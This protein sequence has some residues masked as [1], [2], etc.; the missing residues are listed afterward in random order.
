MQKFLSRL[1]K[2]LM[3]SWSWV[4]LIV[5]T[6]LIKWASWYP[7][8]VENQY[9]YGVYPL[10]TRVQRFLFG[11]I[12]FSIGDLFY[13]FLVLVVIFRT[14]RFF[15]FLFQKKITR[16]FFVGAMQQTIFFFLFVYVFFNLLWGLNYN[17]KGISPQL[18]IEVRKYSLSDIDSL[19]SVLQLRV[20]EYADSASE[21]QRDSFAKKRDLFRES[22]HAYEVISKK[23]PFLAYRPVSVKPSLFSYLGNYLGFQGYYNP[24][25]G[26][27]QVNTTVPRFLEPFI[28]TH[29]IAHQLG[30]GK[31][32]E[33]NFVAFL[34][35]KNHPSPV[36]KYSMYFD[37]YN[38]AINELHK[39][40]STKARSYLRQLHPQAL[41]DIKE[42]RSFYNA[43]RNP[44]EPVITWTYGHFLKANNQ[45]AGKQT[46]NEV[47][48]WLIAY[49]KKYGVENL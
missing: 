41:K 21:V 7:D 5:L 14:F 38:Y 4:L 39:R 9:T 20:N 37:I 42:L 31:E 1:F 17:R 40:D 33:A 26:E 12:P 10:I 2:R 19:T 47:V 27:A 46:Y 44:I 11:W 23:L 35:C 36:F 49:Y 32:N 48:A 30:Y 15:K 16:A 24:F 25:S 34:A 18:G 3:K 8:W 6:I 13:G 22:S 28:T 43:Y 45:P 29:E